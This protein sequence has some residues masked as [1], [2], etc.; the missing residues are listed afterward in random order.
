MKRIMFLLINCLL[1]FSSCD[2]ND[3]GYGCELPPN[4]FSA[5]F[6]FRLVS[7]TGETL[8]ATNG[9]P[10]EDTD[11]EIIDADGEEPFGTYIGRAGSMSFKVAE[12]GE[13]MGL[14]IRK[15][16]YLILPE[17][18]DLKPDTNEI[19]A[20]Y[21]LGL[22]ECNQVWYETFQVSF[23]DSM[24]HTGEFPTDRIDFIKKM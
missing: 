3:D 13:E 16:Y 20:S 17:T 7:E 14:V 21:M 19:R 6:G 5:P 8:I 15:Q 9:A 1:V 10:Y 22:S 12:H 24:Y 2:N 4:A 18:A 23:G 11:V